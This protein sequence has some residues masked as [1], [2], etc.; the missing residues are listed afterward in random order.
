MFERNTGDGIATG[1]IIN[2]DDDPAKLPQHR[3]HDRPQRLARRWADRA[4]RIYAAA[5]LQMTGFSSCAI[6]LSSLPE[7]IGDDD[8]SE[9]RRRVNAALE[10]VL[11]ACEVPRTETALVVTFAARAALAIAADHQQTPLQLK[12][13]VEALHTSCDTC[14]LLA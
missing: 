11:L 6:A 1:H 10:T 2:D 7:L 3:P 5:A 8:V 4:V 13:V 9:A 12:H 14:G